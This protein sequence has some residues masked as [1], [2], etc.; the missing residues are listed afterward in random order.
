MLASFTIT[1]RQTSQEEWTAPEATGGFVRALFYE[2]LRSKSP[3]LAEEIHGSS[4]DAPFTVSPML[5]LRGSAEG[6]RPTYRVRFTTLT[7]P[8]FDAACQAIYP[9]HTTGTPVGISKAQFE[10]QNLDFRQ[11]KRMCRLAR[12]QDLARTRPERIIPF[13]FL[14]P[15]AFKNGKMNVPLPIPRLMFGG[16]L[17]KWN[18]FAPEGLRIDESLLA[19][20]EES[21]LI[22]RH[23]IESRTLAL[24]TMKMVGFTGECA[25]TASNGIRPESLRALNTLAR[26]AFFSGTG[27]KT[28]IGMGQT[29]PA[30]EW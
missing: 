18:T 24:G 13:R 2:L 1:L 6:K 12:Y 14:T 22:S 21:V 27:A 25:L 9:L 30:G 20:V 17:R 15:T 23:D 7:E 8:V 29:A 19:E 10:V 28:T 26:F 3:D 16:Y 11:Q 5:R 4:S